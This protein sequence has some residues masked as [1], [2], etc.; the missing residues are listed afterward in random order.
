[1]FFPLLHKWCVC[2]AKATSG[3]N[4]KKPLEAGEDR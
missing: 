4:Q 3:S 1:L 2:H